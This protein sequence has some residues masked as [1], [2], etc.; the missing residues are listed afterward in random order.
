MVMRSDNTPNY[1]RV[2]VPLTS[3]DFRILKL[4]A[5]S[6]DESLAYYSQQ[7]LHDVINKRVK[8]LFPDGIIKI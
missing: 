5:A 8:E 4:L 1:K 2:S 7:I 6:D 3:A